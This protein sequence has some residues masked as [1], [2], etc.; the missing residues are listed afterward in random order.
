MESSSLC[1]MHMASC[2]IVSFPMHLSSAPQSCCHRYPR[3]FGTF[4]G[5]VPHQKR[6]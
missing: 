5:Y 6:F 3:S 4:N 2:M 1:E